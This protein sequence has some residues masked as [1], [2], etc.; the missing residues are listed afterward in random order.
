MITSSS[1]Y[2][3]QILLV[4][5][6][7][8]FYEF[9]A[10]DCL[11]FSDQDY[12]IVPEPL[13]DVSSPSTKPKQSLPPTISQLTYPTS[14]S[15]KSKPSAL[16]P[17]IGHSIRYSWCTGSLD[18]QS[19][20]APVASLASLDTVDSYEQPSSDTITRLKSLQES[21]TS[22]KELVYEM[23]VFSSSHSKFS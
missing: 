19:S 20:A 1:L 18:S 21:A 23:V 7:V 2:N 6:S 14:S 10:L 3:Y 16:V 15:V 8:K 9:S 4:N 5:P 11:E 17:I 12:V 22:V 13:L